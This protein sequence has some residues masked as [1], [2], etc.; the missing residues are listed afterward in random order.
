M[1]SDYFEVQDTSVVKLH[2]VGK[3]CHVV[4]IFFYKSGPAGSI[5]KFW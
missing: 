1:F 5:G 4:L 3:N 2:G